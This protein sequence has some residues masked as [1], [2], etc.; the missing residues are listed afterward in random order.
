MYNETVHQLF[1]YFKNV[2]NLGWRGVL[3]NIQI[4]SGIS[5]KSVRLKKMSK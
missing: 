1:T 2:Y 4:E 3:Y 5:V